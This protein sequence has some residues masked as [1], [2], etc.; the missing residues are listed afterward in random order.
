MLSAAPAAAD[1]GPVVEITR[2][3]GNQFRVGPAGNP[4]SYLSAESIWNGIEAA[5]RVPPPPGGNYISALRE[6]L[7]VGSSFLG[8]PPAEFPLNSVEDVR[9]LPQGAW[10]YIDGEVSEEFAGNAFDPRYPPPDNLR[11]LR[12]DAILGRN[13]EPAPG[14]VDVLGNIVL[15][16][17][18]YILYLVSWFLHFL[19]EVFGRLFDVILTMGQYADAPFVQVGWSFVRNLLN[20]VFILALLAMAF[21]TIAGLE[22]YQARRLLPRLIVAALLVNFSLAIGGGIVGFS[23]AIIHTELRAAGIRVDPPPQD[24]QNPVGQSDG[25]GRRLGFGIAKS[26]L[27]ER[28]FETG[29]SDLAKAVLGI[30]NFESL[31]PRAGIIK[32]TT[33]TFTQNLAPLIGSAMAAAFL[34]FIA[35]VFGAVTLLFFVRAASLVILL[36]LSPF[37]YALGVIPGGE[38]WSSKWWNRFINYCMFGPIAVLFLVLKIR[39]A[40]TF[41]SVD[42]FSNEFQINTAALGA[43]TTQLVFKLFLTTAFNGLLILMALYFAREFSIEFAGWAQNFSRRLAGGAVASGVFLGTLAPRLAGG[44]LWART[45]APFIAGVKRAREETTK[46]RLRGPAGQLG[47]RAGALLGPRGAR[48]RVERRIE[49]E[50]IKDLTA[51]SVSLEELKKMPGGLGTRTRARYALDKELIRDAGDFEETLKILPVGSAEFNKGA[52]KYQERYSIRGTAFVSRL[53]NQSPDYSA[54]IRGLSPNDSYEAYKREQADWEKLIRSAVVKPTKSLARGI[55]NAS[56]E[57]AA[58]SLAATAGGPGTIQP[59]LPK[60]VEDEL[61]KAKLI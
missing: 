15:T 61:R 16:I 26:L 35:F 42:A 32:I 37:P 43:D 10:I 23:N 13:L 22:S 19:I 30:E 46:E 24:T 53:R 8:I 59:D 14:P 48:E 33:R 11:Q 50:E 6:R 1:I 51:R 20:F 49:D 56:D 47:M 39:F 28:Y 44:A 3:E 45:G 7:F 12:T 29:E 17:L 58:K 31:E 40:S 9:N 18:Y 55:V 27:V 57:G 21:G 38:S 54:A 41:T 36:I 60:A 4:E 5:R 2:I 25:V 52:K 34:F